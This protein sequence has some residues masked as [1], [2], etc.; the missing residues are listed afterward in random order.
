M[1]ITEWFIG[2]VLVLAQL[3]QLP[4]LIMQDLVK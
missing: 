2:V 3:Q 4:L 1:M